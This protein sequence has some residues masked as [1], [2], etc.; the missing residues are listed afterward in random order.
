[1]PPTMGT[2]RT[3]RAY[4][5]PADED[6]TRIL[7]DRIWP[8]GRSKEELALDDWNKEVAPSDGLREWFDH[9]PR[10]WAA[11][12]Q[13]YAK[14]LETNEEAWRP[15]LEAAEEGTLTLVYGAKDTEHNNAEALKRFLEEKTG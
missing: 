5:D 2:I 7:V 1:M 3:K 10:K 12:K 11:F 9:D 4:E 6:G 15:L 8:R 13:K 14:E